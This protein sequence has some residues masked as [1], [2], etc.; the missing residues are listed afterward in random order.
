M[1]PFLQLPGVVDPFLSTDNIEGHPQDCAW[2]ALSPV[3]S[4]CLHQTLA[5]LPVS[6]TE[7]H[8][9]A[10]CVVANFRDISLGRDGHV[11]LRK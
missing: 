9:S 10:C 2:G 6:G 1:E 5:Q 3:G 4:V 7:A 8:Q 11:L